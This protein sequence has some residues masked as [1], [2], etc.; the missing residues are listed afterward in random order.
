MYYATSGITS[1]SLASSGA[2]E[3]GCWYPADDRSSCRRRA[4]RV[5]RC[6]RGSLNPGG[7]VTSTDLPLLPPRPSRHD[8]HFGADVFRHHWPRLLV[9]YHLHAVRHAGAL[10]NG[11]TVK[12]RRKKEDTFFVEEGRGFSTRKHG[13]MTFICFKESPY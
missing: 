13:N 6:R 10:A 2:E 5:C 9:L 11:V 12:G 7:F 3:G 8:R 1:G 4:H